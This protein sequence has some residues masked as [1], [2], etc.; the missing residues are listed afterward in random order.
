MLRRFLFISLIILISLVN[1]A[2]AYADD[3]DEKYIINNNTYYN[4]PDKE[5]TE[6]EKDS[7]IGDAMSRN[8]IY[9]YSLYE[10]KDDKYYVTIRVKMKSFIKDVAFNVQSSE[11]DE[12]YQIVQYEITG[13]NKE[14]DTADYRFELPFENPIINPQFFVI[15][16]DK[17]VKF[18]ITLDMNSLKEDDG[19]F[20][21]NEENVS[22]N[23]PDTEA[24]D[25]KK[26][27]EVET[28]DDILKDKDKNKND[29]AQKSDTRSDETGADEKIAKSEEKSAQKPDENITQVNEQDK[30]TTDTDDI[31]KTPKS[32][33]KVIQN[34]QEPLF[35]G[36][37]PLE[38]EKK[39]VFSGLTVPIILSLT[40]VLAILIFVF[41]K[42]K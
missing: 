32:D 4:D 16:M 9:E 35:V 36:S 13:E 10:K 11:N 26:S 33:D 40:V 17:E 30:E 34:S 37:L 27:S 31:D 41:R 19:S 5:Q 15:P 29:T 28:D 21:G 24:E 1:P 18:F 38:E 42:K 14:N 12:S 2:K 20:L 6:T 25:E 23:V 3:K 7:S 22:D 8:T 39:N